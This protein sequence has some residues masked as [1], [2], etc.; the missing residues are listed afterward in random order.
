MALHGTFS[1][2]RQVDNDKW[3]VR[4]NYRMNVKHSHKKPE[5][6]IILDIFG[7][8]TWLMVQNIDKVMSHYEPGP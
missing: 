1:I 6:F 8:R 5:N 4:E 2:E 3:A 7:R